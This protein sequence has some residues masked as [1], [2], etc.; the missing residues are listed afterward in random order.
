MYSSNSSDKTRNGPNGSQ[1]RLLDQLREQ[2]RYRHYSLQ[3]EK[4]YVFWV[5]QFIRWH[6]RDG[7]IRHPRDMA[8]VE[9][10]AF[11]AML[12]SQ[13]QVS[14]GTHRQALSALLFLYR[15]VLGVNLPWLQQIGRPSVQRRMP[16]VLT[17][18]EVRAL[19]SILDGAEGVL[20]RLLYG[21]GMRLA[22]GLALR[23]KDVDFDRHVIVV[24][25]GKGD[26]DRI[27]ML[28]RSLVPALRG[29]LAQSRALWTADRAA[30]VPGVS[31]LMPCARGQLK[32]LQVS[33]RPVYQPGVA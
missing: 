10:Q 24:R 32:G 9:V 15:H 8:Q 23:V 25:A 14:P 27:V 11:L 21:T 18:D 6:G 26:K 30:A 5:R 31:C 33:P 16:V 29:Q 1:P 4:A 19:L 17:P 12:A 3:T 28:P 20:A 7:H 2:V 13:R 22:E